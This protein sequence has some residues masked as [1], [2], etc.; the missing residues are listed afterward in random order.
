MKTEKNPAAIDGR[1]KGTIGVEANDH[2]DGNEGAMGCLRYESV[3]KSCADSRN[4][5]ESGGKEIYEKFQ[6]DPEFALSEEYENYF[7]KWG[8]SVEPPF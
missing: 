6:A 5:W 8:I 7:L 1:Y 3:E 2:D 4:R